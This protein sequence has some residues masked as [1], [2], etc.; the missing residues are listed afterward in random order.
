MR[1]FPFISGGPIW[2]Q[3]IFL[4]SPWPCWKTESSVWSECE[5]TVKP[6]LIIFVW[7]QTWV[8]MRFSDW[9]EFITTLHSFTHE[10][11]LIRGVWAGPC[12]CMRRRWSPPP[13][14]C[15][16]RPS[17]HMCALHKLTTF[18]LSL[19]TDS[20]HTNTQCVHATYFTQSGCTTPHSAEMTH[21]QEWC[22]TT[23]RQH[24]VNSVLFF[25]FFFFPP[26]AAGR[27]PHLI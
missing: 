11:R 22:R 12:V 27:H 20:R 15:P 3:Q 18:F 14:S 17:N 1:P 5:A 26:N 2:K 10:T 21:C 23:F 16:L 6:W 25:L 19:K 4:E 13:T 24:K 9:Q 7:P 8:K